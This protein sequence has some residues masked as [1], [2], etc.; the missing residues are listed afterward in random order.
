MARIDGKLLQGEDFFTDVPSGTIDGSNVT[1][2]LSQVPSDSSGVKVYLNGLIQI[3][4]TNFSITG[5]TIT[6]VV[7]PATGQTMLTTYLKEN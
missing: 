1:F 2:T 7:A 5:Q 3:P 6:M 4:T